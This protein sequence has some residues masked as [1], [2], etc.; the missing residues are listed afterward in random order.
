MPDRLRLDAKNGF[1]VVG[2]SAPAS[3]E[4]F[5][6]AIG[7]KIARDHA[8]NKIWALEGYML[9][10][11]LHVLEHLSPEMRE[12]VAKNSFDPIENISA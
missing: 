9:K 8:R 11:K 2:E 5:D 12:I 7:R 1:H 4:N 6:E 10:T 3:P